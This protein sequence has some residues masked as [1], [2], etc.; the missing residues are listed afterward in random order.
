M[1]YFFCFH[2]RRIRKPGVSRASEHIFDRA[3][4]LLLS[5]LTWLLV[6]LLATLARFLRLLPGL[7]ILSALLAAMARVLRLLARLLI[8]FALVLLSALVWV[9]H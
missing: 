1:R 3:T 8:L 2:G 5:L 9:V 6:A 7:L 4:I